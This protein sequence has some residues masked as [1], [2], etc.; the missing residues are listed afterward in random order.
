MKPVD[1]QVAEE[2]R[3]E[4]LEHE[5]L[6]LQHVANALEG[7]GRVDASP[8]P[9]QDRDGQRVPHEVLPGEEE[10]VGADA[11]SQPT[12]PCPCRPR[13]FQ[14]PVDRGENHDRGEPTGEG[15]RFF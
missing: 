12:L 4:R 15:V 3:L 6:A 5:G 7:A 10:E 13:P 1:A 11:R 2:Q 14:R 8:Q 9:H